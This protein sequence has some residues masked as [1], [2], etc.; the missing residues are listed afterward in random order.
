MDLSGSALCF[1]AFNLQYIAR[2]SLG[3]CNF[4]TDRA[5][6]SKFGI[7]QVDSEEFSVLRRYFSRFRMERGCMEFCYFSNIPARR[8]CVRSF[9]S[10]VIIVGFRLYTFYFRVTGV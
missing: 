3:L 10:E 1:Y 8:A 5:G 4:A 2:R 7:S 9:L 6:S